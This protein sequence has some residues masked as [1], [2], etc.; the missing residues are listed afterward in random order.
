[1][2]SGCLWIYA[3]SLILIDRGRESIVLLNNILQEGNKDHTDPMS[4]HG[5]DPHTATIIFFRHLKPHLKFDIRFKVSEGFAPWW[6]TA[7][8]AILRVGLKSE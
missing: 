6:C 1:M 3:V 8:M 2:L 7:I 5:E 4:V